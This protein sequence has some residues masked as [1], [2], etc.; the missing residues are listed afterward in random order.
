MTILQRAACC[1]AAV[2]C[3]AAFTPFDIQASAEDVQTVTLTPAQTRALFGDEISITYFDGMDWV[4]GTLSYL[5]SAAEV[6]TDPTFGSN[7]QHDLWY[8]LNPSGTRYIVY[9][10]SDLNIQANSQY[11][12]NLEPQI[13]FTNTQLTRFVCGVSCSSSYSAQ[14]RYSPYNYVSYYNNGNLVTSS[15]FTYEQGSMSWWLPIHFT[16][17]TGQYQ[18]D[19][20]FLMYPIAYNQDTFSTLNQFRFTAD[21]SA[22]PATN[23]CRFIVSCPT[24]SVSTST[25]SGGGQTG[26]DLTSTNMKLDTIISILSLLAQRNETPST[27]PGNSDSA[28]EGDASE[29]N[30][31]MDDINDQFDYLDSFEAGLDSYQFQE[32]QYTDIYPTVKGFVDQNPSDQLVPGSGSAETLPNSMQIIQ[33]ELT[34]QGNIFKT[35]ML[36][37]ACIALI[38]FVIF[39]KWGL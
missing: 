14:P 12:V 23:I 35:M 11:Q 20:Y 30:D 1:L 6:G 2:G 39:G 16:V 31:S 4:S 3:V 28:V 19:R 25:G 27:D 29:F 8:S 34:G 26:T 32:A 10:A 22:M 5:T 7:W 13:S 21:S 9:S 24:I 37:T 15:A 33:G 38:S 18:Q 36:V 17:G